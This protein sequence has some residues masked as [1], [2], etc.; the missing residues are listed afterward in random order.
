LHGAAL[1]SSDGDAGGCDT[2][3][4]VDANRI[5]YEHGNPFRDTDI[6]EHIYTHS[7]Y[8]AD[9]YGNEYAIAD[10]YCDAHCH[11]S[12]PIDRWSR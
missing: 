8:H 11:A 10:F 7:D 3:A 12:D 1:G 6:N 4:N 9:S 2:D 5:A